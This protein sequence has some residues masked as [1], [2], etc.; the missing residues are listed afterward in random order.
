MNS[1]LLLIVALLGIVFLFYKRSS[2][3]QA[4]EFEE[5][6]DD[7]VD[8]HIDHELEAMPYLAKMIDNPISEHYTIFP[9]YVQYD[10]EVNQAKFLNRNANQTSD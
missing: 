7:E 1:T 8:D 2:Q 5:I 3:K 4:E 6:E 9:L 10:L